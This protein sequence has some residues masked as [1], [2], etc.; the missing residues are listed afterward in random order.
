M[1]ERI[2]GKYNVQ[3]CREK[4]DRIYVKWFL[5]YEWKRGIVLG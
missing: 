3:Q 4:T 5:R 1:D 2:G